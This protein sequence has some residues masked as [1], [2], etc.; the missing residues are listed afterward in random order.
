[1]DKKELRRHIRQLKESYTSAQHSSMSHAICER[2][3]SLP[4][5]HEAHTV[6]LY[7]SL[8]DEV[9]T[10]LLLAAAI[11]QGKQVLL[12]VVLNDTDMQ[13]RIYEGPE[14]MR[15]GS[16]GILEPIGPIFPSNRYSSISLAIIPGMSFDDECHRL[17]RGKGY[18]DRLLPQLSDAYLLGIC[19][20]FQL[21]SHIPSDTHDVLMNEIVT[22]PEQK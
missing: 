2:V 7:H 15:E 10:S 19:F 11:Q 9:D 14:S 17:G 22:I 12:P 16:Y 4:Q 3:L 8:P 20:P 6:F 18:Y 5:W 21:L 1:M 13:L